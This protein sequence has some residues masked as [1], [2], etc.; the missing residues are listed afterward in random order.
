MSFGALCYNTKN[1]STPFVGKG[2]SHLQGIVT[3]VM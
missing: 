1:A 2:I 3:Y